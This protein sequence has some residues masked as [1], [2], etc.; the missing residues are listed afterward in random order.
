MFSFLFCLHS[1]ANNLATPTLS[2][3]QEKVSVWDNVLTEP[4]RNALHRVA[5]AS[6]LGHHVFQRSIGASNLIEQTLD[7]I[8]T[9]IGD[10]TRQFVEYWSRQEWRHIEAH[11]DVDENLAKEQDRA[12]GGL[13]TEAFRYPDKGHVLYLK[14]GTDVRGPT[15]VFTNQTTGGELSRGDV[16]LVTVPAVGGRLLRFEG[17]FLHAVPRPT[18]IWF[19]P[20]VQG[21]PEFLPEETYGRSVILFNTWSEE[22]P[23]DVVVVSGTC[24]TSGM[25]FPYEIC[26][27]KHTWKPQKIIELESETKEQALS[28]KVWLL[29]NER[30][31]D[32]RMRTVSL[33][34]S[35][36]TKEALY[37]ASIPRKSYL[38][39]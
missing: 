27:S 32:S 11:A 30:R 20:F 37:E 15:C 16:E 9:E 21:G 29:G 10:P 23:K 12:N 22:P 39:R 13:A 5:K 6:G 14:I 3:H 36:V 26:N 1:T 25:E 4:A 18:D 7:A 38:G 34:A 17:N 35:V 8:L 28:A 24:E 19:L 33:V 31:R 2:T